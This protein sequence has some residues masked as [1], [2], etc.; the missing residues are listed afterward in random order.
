MCY[1]KSQDILQCEEALQVNHTRLSTST[2][3]E[4]LKLRRLAAF[5]YDV[6]FIIMS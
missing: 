1:P 4:N 5:E 6:G 2:E 3:D